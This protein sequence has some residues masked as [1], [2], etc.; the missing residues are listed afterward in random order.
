M[1][2]EQSELKEC[3]FCCGD[4]FTSY[5]QNGDERIGYNITHTITC[6][7]C[8]CSKSARS[9]QDKNGWC[10]EGSLDVK[11]RAVTAWNS[12]PESIEVL[13]SELECASVDIRTAQGIIERKQDEIEHLKAE[14][15][16]LKGSSSLEKE[17][18]DKTLLSLLLKGD[19]LQKDADRY[20]WL[21]DGNG[22][23]MEEQMLC[24]HSNEKAEADRQI[25]IAMKTGERP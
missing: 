3:P 18:S 10:I 17:L 8:G 20:R 15:N 2:S 5:T 23:F 16:C 12:R 4:K 7:T 11:K 14:L 22:Y 9:K 21:C 25:D 13:K 24:G 19:R 6:S 1:M